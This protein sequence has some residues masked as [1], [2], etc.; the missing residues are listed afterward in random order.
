MTDP[1]IEL[2]TLW[3][4]KTGC[5]ASVVYEVVGYHYGIVKHCV[6]R[7]PR[8]FEYQYDIFL[9]DFEMLGADDVI[10]ETGGSF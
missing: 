10:A 6:H 3:R 5:F 8:I 9:R 4:R 2:N 7:K 1:T